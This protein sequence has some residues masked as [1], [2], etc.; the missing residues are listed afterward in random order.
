MEILMSETCWAHKKWNKIASDIKLVFYSSAITND[1]RSDKHK[2]YGV[3]ND[4]PVVHKTKLNEA[5][6]HMV[7]SVCVCMYVYMCVYIYIYIYR[8]FSNLIRTSFVDF[9]NEKN[10]QFAV[11]IRTFPSTAPCLQGRLIE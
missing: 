6:R 7:S 11:P 5:N 9:L 8:I 2:Y 3:Q 4:R 10:S 1:A